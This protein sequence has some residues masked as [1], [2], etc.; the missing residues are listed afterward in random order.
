M[1]KYPS[2][3]IF[4]N[5]SALDLVYLSLI[6]LNNSNNNIGINPVQNNS[7]NSINNSPQ[8]FSNNNTKFD[9]NNSF[10]YGKSTNNQNTNL[11]TLYYLMMLSSLYNDTSNKHNIADN[12]VDDY[13]N[14]LNLLL[15]NNEEEN[16]FKTNNLPNKLSSNNSD[17]YQNYNNKLNIYD[18]TNLISRI[19]STKNSFTSNNLYKEI[20]AVKKPS[21]FEEQMTLDY[22]SNISIYDQNYIKIS[23]EGNLSLLGKKRRK[24]SSE[25]SC[26]SI[27]S[28]ENCKS[29]GNS[30][31][32]TEIDYIKKNGNYKSTEEF[33]R[34]FSFDKTA[35]TSSLNNNFL[36]KT[37]KESKNYII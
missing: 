14:L 3:L 20:N 13:S 24:M 15:K 30:M 2:D 19:D 36:F 18:N 29:L 6:S 12:K 21:N 4:N 25:D 26:S 31:S 16:A 23:K 22:T 8:F 7:I 32:E 33:I 17:L 5:N 1:Q 27:K 10:Y 34:S 9:N 11:D 37:K 35:V 28:N